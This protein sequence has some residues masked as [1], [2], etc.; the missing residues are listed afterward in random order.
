MALACLL[1]ITAL[2]WRS[3]E[4]EMQLSPD[5]RLL[6]RAVLCPLQKE[7]LWTEPHRGASQVLHEAASG[8]GVC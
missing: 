7:D 4:L 8:G 1:H 6:P 3:L 5:M 2:P